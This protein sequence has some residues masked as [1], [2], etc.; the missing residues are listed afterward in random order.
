ME[1]NPARLYS[2]AE[3]L[4]V[5]FNFPECGK[6]SA[7]VSSQVKAALAAKLPFLV[8]VF[9]VRSPRESLFPF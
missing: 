5:K 4:K 1:C 8:F 2:A 9:C 7:T 6:N 3:H